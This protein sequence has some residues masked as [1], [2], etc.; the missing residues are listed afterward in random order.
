MCWYKDAANTFQVEIRDM[1]FLSAFFHAKL[2]EPSLRNDELR[3]NFS[4]NLT[5]R[6]NL[7]PG[8]RL[9]VTLPQEHIRVY[10]KQA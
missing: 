9:T 3:A 8:Q 10:A 6:L 4:A 5:R 2:T 7:Q 1:E